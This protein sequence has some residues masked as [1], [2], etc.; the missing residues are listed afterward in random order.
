MDIDTAVVLVSGGDTQTPYTTPTEACSRGL[1]A[2]QTHTALREA[3]L[4]AGH[5]VF[6]APS[7]NG[8]GQVHASGE[9]F[10]DFGDGP[11]PLP[12]KLTVNSVGPIDTGGRH[13]AA[14]VSFL[15]E[16]FGI[17][18]IHLVGHSMGGMFSRSAIRQL[19][20]QSAPVEVRSLTTLGTPWRGC[21]IADVVTGVEDETL[22]AD[23][24]TAVESA[25]LLKQ[26]AEQRPGGLIDEVTV[27]FIE[28]EGQRGS[29]NA[30]QAGVLDGIPITVIGGDYCSLA[31]GDPR[32]WPNDSLV[33]TYSQVA[34]GL[35]PAIAPAISRVTF[36]TVHSLTYTSLLG[37]AHE[38]AMTW[39]PE[40]LRV[41]VDAIEAASG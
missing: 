7:M 39:H 33:A 36:P 41:V 26:A 37:L 5:A 9:G 1:A 19:R 6:T 17:R 29:W 8:P 12:A 24:R 20:A 4:A 35:D 31:G 13:L 25:A 34:D 14:F 23:Q 40:S 22:L 10:D 21:I 16:R 11:D 32:L 30:E 3:L 18:S 2:G 38:A 27:R 15:R 28:G